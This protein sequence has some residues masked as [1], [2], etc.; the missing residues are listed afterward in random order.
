VAALRGTHLPRLLGAGVLLGTGTLLGAGGAWGLVVGI[1]LLFA[2]TS[3]ASSGITEKNTSSKSTGAVI[4]A[5]SREPPSSAS[6][7]GAE[8][9]VS[10]MLSAAIATIF[11]VLLLIEFHPGRDNGGRLPHCREQS[12]WLGVFGGK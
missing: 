4:S 11:D 5:T 3:S 8:V 1:G 2:A 9:G 10:T 6:A 12:L 7:R